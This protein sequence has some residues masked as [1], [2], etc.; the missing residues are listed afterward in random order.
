MVY[1]VTGA[2]DFVGSRLVSRLKTSLSS[3]AL[4]T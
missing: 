4:V 2:T 3:E 1:F